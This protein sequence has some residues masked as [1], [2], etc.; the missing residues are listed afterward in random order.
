MN[1]SC[2][3]AEEATCVTVPGPL[4]TVVIPTRDRHEL[5]ARAARSVLAQTLSNFEVI[6]VDDASKIPVD[7]P[8]FAR[9]GRVYV[10]RN[11]QP[12]GVCGARNRGM[13]QARGHWITFLDDDD[14]LL[15]K[16]LEV[17][18][19]AARTSKLTPPISVLS[20]TQSVDGAGTVGET[21][22]PITLARGESFFRADA[23]RKSF[24]EVVTLVAP[25]E[26]FKSIGGW[27]EAYRA[28]EDEDLLLRLSQASSIQGVTQTTY[29][30][31]SHTGEHLS[32][33]T[34]AMIAGAE[35]TLAKHPRAFAT[36]PKRHARYLRAL[37]LL[38]LRDGALRQALVA[39]ANAL[40][41]DPRLPR[42]WQLYVQALPKTL[43]RR[44]MPQK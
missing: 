44:R 22:F 3:A 30:V 15:P 14:E 9:D 2:S 10:V 41:L 25:L 4:V 26:L 24:Q 31:H 43:R 40:R 42:S 7:L 37:G 29:R 28:W 27:D 5:L 12:Q 21:R 16:M 32:Y 1:A 20:G 19:E 38:Y 39:L 35:R 23:H 13:A 11:D 17:S 6:V 18:L 36:D 33:D 8:D 34:R